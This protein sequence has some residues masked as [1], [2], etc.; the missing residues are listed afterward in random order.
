VRPSRSTQVAAAFAVIAVV[1][2]L[3]WS[4]GRALAAPGR[5][6]WDMRTVEWLRDHH[7]NG[8][9]DRGESWW[10]WHHLP[11]TDAQLTALPVGGAAAAAVPAAPTLPAPVAPIVQPALPGEGNWTVAKVDA[12][13]RTQIATTVLRPDTAHPSLTVGLASMDPAAVRFVLVAGT[14]EPGGGVGP[15]GASV[16]SGERPG[17]LAAFNSGYR[18]KDT[19]GGAL[20]EGHRVRSFAAGL[21]TL[22]VRADGTA[23]VGKWGRD[24]GS[25]SGLVAA[26]RNLHLI[27]DDAQ[28]VDGLRQNAGGQWGTVRNALP[29]WRS[30]VGVDSAGRLIYAAGNQLTL[31]VLA[32]S[33]QQAGAV[34]A[35]ELDIHNHMVTYNVFSP[36]PR[37]TGDLIGHK[38][39]P[40]MTESA[41]RYLV[42]DRRDFVAVLSR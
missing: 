25:G 39:L 24:V 2:G 5:A 32:R 31:D 13:G 33:L 34:R 28:L 18:M 14:R 22:A 41:N 15:W 4:Y 27:V 11:S 16:P 38:L 37:G 12:S 21:A 8:V 20:V 6:A 29:T 3:S 23:T 10:L 9:V 17:L 42:P 19:P 35:M 7:V 36:G 30:G 26:R 40:D 1:G